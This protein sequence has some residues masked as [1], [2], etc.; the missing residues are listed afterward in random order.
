MSIV[1]GLLTLFV[2]VPLALFALQYTFQN[3][4]KLADHPVI[5]KV[6]SV[7]AALLGGKR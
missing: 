1:F 2:L 5:Q 3:A 7:I 4:G 6:A